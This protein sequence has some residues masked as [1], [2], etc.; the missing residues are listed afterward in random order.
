[1]WSFSSYSSVASLA[2]VVSTTCII[3]SAAAQDLTQS[4]VSCRDDGGS[5]MVSTAN[6]IA[7]QVGIDILEAGGTAA[8]ALVAVQAV[9]GLVEPQ[10]SGLGGGSFAVYFDAAA[11]QVTTLDGREKAPAAA[12]D[13][14]FATL[15]FVGAWQ[16]GLSVGVPGTPMLLEEM[17]NRYGS[18]DFSFAELF[19]PA[20]E[21]AGTTGFPLSERTHA[22]IARVSGFLNQGGCEDRLF[23]RDPIAFEYFYD[24]PGG[25]NC[26]IK[27]PGT[28]MSNPDYAATLLALVESG[29][30]SFY[31]GDIAADIAAAVQSD[32]AIPGDMTVQDLASYQVVERTP[33]CIPY[34]SDTMKIC[35]MGPPTSGGLAVGQIMGISE[36]LLEY[37]NATGADANPLD[38]ANVHLFTQANRLAFADRNQYVADPDFVEV[39]SEGMLNLDYLAERATLVDPNQDMGTALPG[40]PPGV[41]YGSSRLPADSK[42]KTTGTS[43][44]SIVDSYG[45]AATMTS[46]IEAPFG[47]GVMVRGFLLNNELTDFSF[48]A[49]D[50]EGAPIANRAEGNK[51][52]RSSM[53][54]TIVLDSQTGLPV[55]L[56]GSPGGGSIPAYTANSLWNVLEFGLDPQASINTPHYMNN[57]EGTQIEDPASA[58]PYLTEYDAAALQIELETSFGHESVTISDRLTSGVAMVEATDEAWIGGADPRRDG[59]VGPGKECAGAPSEAPSAGEGLDPGMTTDSP[60]TADEASGGSE[61]SRRDVVVHVLRLLHVWFILLTY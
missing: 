33:V 49:T 26:T 5:G 30:D 45:N 3:T 35:G 6:P 15:G 9:L 20:I 31:R 43:H 38:A 18:G 16:S 25:E 39:P 57:N 4:V 27:P 41:E 59:A 22:Q 60:A 13:D 19:A 40:T 11:N 56:T 37:R 17:L 21:L 24:N 14:R 36:Q 23:F 48:A 28:I 55:L 54:P 8:D 52:P 46:S 7:T 29:S 2:A 1:M 44:I 47:N 10:S 53:S 32:L 12:T 51:R 50:A 61:F 42:V 34:K 58:A